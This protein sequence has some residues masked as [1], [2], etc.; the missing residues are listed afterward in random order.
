MSKLSGISEW[1]NNSVNEWLAHLM[2]AGL[3]E[4]MYAP[5]NKSVNECM[6]SVNVWLPQQWNDSLRQLRTAIKRK[7]EYITK[8]MDD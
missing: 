3:N 1:I 5:V 2:S 8:W 4:W 7:D 6:N